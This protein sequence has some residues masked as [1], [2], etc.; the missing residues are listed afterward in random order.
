MFFFK[1]QKDCSF[2]IQKKPTGESTLIAV[3]KVGVNY[4]MFIRLYYQSLQM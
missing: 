3:K 4:L 2:Y 1:T